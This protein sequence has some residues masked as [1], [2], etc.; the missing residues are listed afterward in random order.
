MLTAVQ[1]TQQLL[2]DPQSAL[3]VPGWQLP[4]VSQ[5]PSH[6]P[7]KHELPEL[8]VR[9]VA[10]PSEPLSLP[11]SR[12]LSTS[13]LSWTGVTSLK[14]TSTELTSSEPTSPEPNGLEPTSLISCEPEPT[15]LTLKPPESAVGLPPLESGLSE[16]PM[17][18]NVSS[19]PVAH[20][21][22]NAAATSSACLA[23]SIL[24]QVSMNGLVAK[25]YYHL[26]SRP[27]PTAAIRPLDGGCPGGASTR[28]PRSRG[29]DSPTEPRAAFLSVAD[30]LAFVRAA[31]RASSSIP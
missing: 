15:S 23:S 16:P 9:H 26:I 29:H 18:S 31:W 27:S 1:S 30:Q 7:L 28:S 10:L 20:A 22:K 14:V 2:R 6:V 13:P 4:S 25:W 8:P 3:E 21:V 11:P 17:G 19:P 24:G 12:L 5:H